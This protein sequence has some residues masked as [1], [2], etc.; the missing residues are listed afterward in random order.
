MID[1]LSGNS[2]QITEE[3][4]FQEERYLYTAFQDYSAA[5]ELHGSDSFFFFLTKQHFLSL[6]YK[7][8][9]FSLK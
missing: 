2:D 6:K 7:H 9:M 3:M 4:K 8:I 1:K 5:R